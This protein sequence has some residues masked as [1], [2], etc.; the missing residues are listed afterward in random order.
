LWQEHAADTQLE[1]RV[2]EWRSRIEPLLCVEEERHA[3]D[4]KQYGSSILDR[5]RAKLEETESRESDMCALFDASEP[6]E[7]CRNFLAALQLVNSY[8]IDIVRG[9]ADATSEFNP[10]VTLLMF[11]GEGEGE[12]EGEGRLGDVSAAA[13]TPTKGRARTPLRERSQPLGSVATPQTSPAPKTPRR[14]G[15]AKRNRQAGSTPA[16]ARRAPSKARVA[17]HQGVP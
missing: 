15:P 8:K 2:A 17:L 11:D 16:S 6:F 13:R 12:G 14:R 4:I 3:F 1:Q 5:F 9:D 10:R 7:V